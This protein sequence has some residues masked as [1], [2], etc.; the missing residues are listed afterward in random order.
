[1]T[2]K[3]MPLNLKPIDRSGNLIKG[4]SVADKLERL[5]QNEA[6]QNLDKAGY[7]VKD[8]PY[9]KIIPNSKN[10]YAD[11]DIDILASS[12][13]LFGLIHFPEVKELSDGT[14][15]LISGERRWRAIGKIRKKDPGKF[16]T[17]PCSV[18]S[19]DMSAIMEE[20]RMLVAN[21][22]VVSPEP[23]EYRDG[24]LRLQNLYK[25]LKDSGE[26]LPDSMNQWIAHYLN[27]SERQVQKISSIN[28]KLIPELQAYFDEKK[29]NIAQGSTIAQLDPIYQEEILSLLQEKGSIDADDISFYKDEDK[30]LRSEN[31]EL[32]T[33]LIS[34]RKQYSESVNEAKELA[35]EHPEQSEQVFND[36]Q[37]LSQ[38]FDSKVA[39]IKQD[40]LKSRNVDPKEDKRITF[41]GALTRIEKAGINLKS[42]SKK[43]ELNPLDVARVEKIIKEL[44]ELINN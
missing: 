9:D 7:V 39:R 32:R 29:L 2:K 24:I 8:I 10:R 43:I 13:S 36:V 25:E 6:H 41:E 5:E 31:A 21:F 12:I 26:Y 23:K 20:A 38:E 33:E 22:D 34:L 30:R 27:I 42:K 4:A 11:R 37:R 44:Q 3:K 18:K 15:E 16:E 19:S 40:I 28:H 14:Y 35:S 17:V 1:M